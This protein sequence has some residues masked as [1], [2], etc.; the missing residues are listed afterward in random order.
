[1]KLAEILRRK[2]SDVYTIEPEK[3]VAEAVQRLV[4]CNCGSL[5]VTTS[6]NS[7]V[8]IGIITERDILKAST[9]GQERLEKTAISEVMSMRVITGGREDTVA[10]AMG[11]M[12]KN[13]IRHLPI[14]EN[15]ELVGMISIGDVVKA[16]FD[17]LS[18]ENHYLKNYIQS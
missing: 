5:V 8:L 18:L 11:L 10:A 15:S 3:T 2:G 17:A 1:M 7:R 16:Q 13:R 14:V 6:P 9:A 12:T 4:D